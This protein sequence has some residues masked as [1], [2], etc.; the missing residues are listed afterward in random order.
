MKRQYIS[1]FLVLVSYT[2]FCVQIITF[3]IYQFAFIPV[4]TVNIVHCL[5][6]ERKNNSKANLSFCLKSIRPY[7]SQY[8][9]FTS[10]IFK[11]L[12]STWSGRNNDMFQALYFKIHSRSYWQEFCTE[13]LWFLTL[14]I[15]LHEKC[16]YFYINDSGVQFYPKHVA[17]ALAFLVLI[18]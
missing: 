2:I 15:Y 6:S 12:L 5:T 3:F 9:Q 4:Y 17:I 13:Y 8:L 7:N 16:T 10:S 11:H 18:W 14:V 1:N